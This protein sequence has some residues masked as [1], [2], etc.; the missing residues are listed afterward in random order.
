M[1]LNLE[2]YDAYNIKVYLRTLKVD[3]KQ[4]INKPHKI[5]S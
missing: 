4:I 2:G 1:T 5:Y 3:R